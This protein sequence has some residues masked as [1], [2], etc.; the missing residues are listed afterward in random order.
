M[1]DITIVEES[2]Q[3]GK[4]VSVLFAHSVSL[5]ELERI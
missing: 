5:V 1:V 4:I 2:H 3:N